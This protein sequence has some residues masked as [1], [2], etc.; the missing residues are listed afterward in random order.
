MC[1]ASPLIPAI[2]THPSPSMAQLMCY[3]LHKVTLY[4]HFPFP[5]DT[6]TNLRYTVRFSWA[7]HMS[8]S[9]LHAQHLTQVLAH[10]RSSINI[11]WKGKCQLKFQS[12]I[13][14]TVDS[15]NDI[16]PIP[17]GLSPESYL[18]ARLRRFKAPTSS[19]TETTKTLKGSSMLS[20]LK[21]NKKANVAHV[22][23]QS[24]KWW[25]TPQCKISIR[26]SNKVLVLFLRWKHK[27]FIGALN[28][29]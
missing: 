12:M 21:D 22:I 4:F 15:K 6:C 25:L 1:K 2:C 7:E 3:L 8:Y 18:R 27:A 29:S 24:I 9:S 19:K 17:F 11:C 14:D 13:I 23:D 10:R 20:M 5:I 16:H 26:K 28:A